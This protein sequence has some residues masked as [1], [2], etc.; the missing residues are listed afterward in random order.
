MSERNTLSVCLNSLLNEIEE[1]VA[2]CTKKPV[3]VKAFSL[4]PTQFMD[5]STL[6]VGNEDITASCM[7]NKELVRVT[8]WKVIEKEVKK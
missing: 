1:D 3:D 2:R 8:E 5:F 6:I 7:V 4:I